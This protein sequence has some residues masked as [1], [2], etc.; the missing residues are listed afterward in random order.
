MNKQ[1]VKHHQNSDTK[2]RQH[3]TTS[4]PPAWNGQE[5]ITGGLNMFY[6]ANLTLSYWRGTNI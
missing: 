4:E 1:K 5:W 6:G 2:N 3:R